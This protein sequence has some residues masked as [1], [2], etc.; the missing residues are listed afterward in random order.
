[1]EHGHREAVKV[2]IGARAQLESAKNV[3]LLFAIDFV[4][5]V[6]VKDGSTALIVA[7]E[8]GDV[9]LLER[10]LEG[11]ANPNSSRHVLC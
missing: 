5:F 1:M 6:G 9:E 4:H 8:K 7:S 2:L 11:K 3:L 10:L